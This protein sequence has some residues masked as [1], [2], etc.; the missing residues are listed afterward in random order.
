MNAEEARKLSNKNGRKEILEM[1]LKQVE[2][3]IYEAAKKGK[4]HI[5]YGLKPQYGGFSI[6]V[7]KRYVDVPELRDVLISKGFEFKDTGYIGGV[8]QH[9]EDLYW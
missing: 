7:N 9:T 2:K 8:Y 6:R 5:C 1:A 3:E 4:N